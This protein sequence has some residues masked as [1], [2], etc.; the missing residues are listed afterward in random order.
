MK[1]K[2]KKRQFQ[3]D[4]RNELENKKLQQQKLIEEKNTI[5]RWIPHYNIYYKEAFR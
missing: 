4:K 2:K 1:M 3:S 5:V